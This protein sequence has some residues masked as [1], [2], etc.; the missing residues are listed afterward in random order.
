MAALFLI[1]L[2]STTYAGG[3]EEPIL[4]APVFPQVGDEFVYARFTSQNN[5]DADKRKWEKHYSVTEV[6]PNGFTMEAEGKSRKRFDGSGNLTE[7]RTKKGKVTSYSPHTST[8]LYPIQIGD[9]HKVSYTKD[10]S[11][12]EVQF[13]LLVSVI[14]WEDVTVAG[15]T[16]RALHIK[17]EGS[18]TWQGYVGKTSTD[19]WLAPEARWQ[20]ILKDSFWEWTGGSK[21]VIM[22]LVGMKLK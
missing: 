18:Y 9:T 8:F 10:D 22:G 1:A 21:G 11:D 20:Y 15:K 3:V 19:E 16:W 17:H 6:S 12:G 5:L 4:T 7:Y 14:G 2:T 13:N